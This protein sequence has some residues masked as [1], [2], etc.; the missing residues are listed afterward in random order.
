MIVKSTDADTGFV[1]QA[2]VVLAP[3]VGEERFEP[4]CGFL[5]APG[6]VCER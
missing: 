3:C 6:V 4:N 5:V 2:D 1:A